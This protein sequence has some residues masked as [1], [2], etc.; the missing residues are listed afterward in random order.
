M[1]YINDE[2]FIHR[3]FKKIFNK[4]IMNDEFNYC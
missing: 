3:F 4:F 2:I 1:K